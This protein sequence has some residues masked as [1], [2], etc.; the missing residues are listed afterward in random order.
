MI[1]PAGK[2]FFCGSL[3]YKTAQGLVALC[4]VQKE[5][6]FLQLLTPDL[7]ID[8]LCINFLGDRIIAEFRL[9]SFYL[10]T[11]IKAIP[12]P[13]LTKPATK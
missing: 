5:N 7:F 10:Y 11:Y 6:Y 9:S 1:A 13:K 4:T 12:E 3:D 2:I 8:K